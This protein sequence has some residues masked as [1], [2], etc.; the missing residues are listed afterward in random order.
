MLL[1][2]GLSRSGLESISMS[3][4]QSYLPSKLGHRASNTHLPEQWNHCQTVDKCMFFYNK[5][6]YSLWF[7]TPL[8]ISL[9]KGTQDLLFLPEARHSN[10]SQTMRT[11]C[12][13]QRQIKTSCLLSA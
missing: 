13:A 5:K 10:S 6:K 4:R 12:R 7:V 3:S 8:A 1:T 9:E 2:T 11:E